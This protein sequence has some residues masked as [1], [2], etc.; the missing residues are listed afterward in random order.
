MIK[1]LMINVH[2]SCN[3]GDDALTLV[4]L[5]QLKENFP[6]SK[7]SLAID[8]PSSYHGQEAVLDSLYHWVRSTK[9]RKLS[10]WNF[11]RLLWVVPACLF[12]LLS[13]RWIKKTFFWLT[14]PALR[15]LLQA[16][17]T[18]DLVVSKPG[19]FLYS[20]GRGINL[21]LAM[22]SMALPLIA[23]KPLYIFPQSIGPLRYRWE[24]FLL[25]NLLRHTRVI[26]IR[27]SSTAKQLQQCKIQNSR[28]HQ[29]PDP[30]FAFRGASSSTAYAWL[31]RKGFEPR[32]HIQ[33]L[34]GITLI[35]WGAENR[36]FSQQE[37]YES[38][39]EAVALHFT[40]QYNGR[41]IFFTQ[42]WGPSE[43]QDDR[44]PLRR[45]K[46]RLADS[47]PSIKFIDTPLSPDLL[48]S[49]YGQ[50]DAF[51]GTRMHSNI[52]ALSQGIPVIGIAYQPKTW[53]IFGML[54]MQE[55]VIDI[56]NVSEQLIIERLDL[57]LSSLE[58]VKE[59][60]LHQIPEIIQ[61]AGSPGKI[62]ADDYAK[63]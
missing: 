11:P 55:W 56:Q 14:P 46:T 25:R 43:S 21:L 4:S 29:L 41:V 30:A 16:Y 6:D 17:L 18:T 42:V 52:F 59:Q 13:A 51:I 60:L 7:V 40:R 49:L 45:L 38:A 54:D 61:E 23:G 9:T 3:A 39:M 2:S 36:H 26:M 19:G 58:S 15:P 28:I 27:E 35:N 63:L 50:M 5:Q 44:I 34:L 22:L 8:D 62:I 32:D 20:S 53:G 10:G 57:L 31:Q 48:W 1:I 47:N 12:P 37:D 24:C 33:P